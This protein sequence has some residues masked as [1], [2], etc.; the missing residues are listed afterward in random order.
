MTTV[1]LIIFCISVGLVLAIN[2]DDYEQAKVSCLKFVPGSP[3]V[4]RYA[5][6]M[7]TTPPKDLPTVDWWLAIKPA[8]YWGFHYYDS[9]MADANLQNMTFF[10]SVSGTKKALNNFMLNHY[11]VLHGRNIRAAQFTHGGMAKIQNLGKNTEVENVNAL[12]ALGLWFNDQPSDQIKAVPEAGVSQTELKNLLKDD[13]LNKLKYKWK[14]AHSKFA[15][16]LEIK[17]DKTFGDGYIIDHSIPQSPNDHQFM[18]YDWSLEEFLGIGQDIDKPEKELLFNWDFFGNNGLAKA[19]HLFCFN[20]DEAKKILPKISRTLPKLVL[21]TVAKVYLD[22]VLATEDLALIQEFLDLKGAKAGADTCFKKWKELRENN[23]PLTLLTTTAEECTQTFNVQTNLIK[24]IS[25]SPTPHASRLPTDKDGGKDEISLAKL[26]DDT[27]A[28]NDILPGTDKFQTRLLEHRTHKAIKEDRSSW[29]QLKKFNA[30]FAKNL[31]GEKAGDKLLSYWKLVMKKHYSKPVHAT[32]LGPLPWMMTANALKT[33]LYV[34]TWSNIDLPT[35]ILQNTGVYL[36]DGMTM[37]SRR[38]ATDTHAAYET[39]NWRHGQSHEK[40]GVAL[41]RSDDGKYWTCVADGNHRTSEIS[42][43]GVT[44][45]ISSES[46]WKS[47]TAK[48]QH[49]PSAYISEGKIMSGGEPAL[50]LRLAELNN[51]N[52][53]PPV[54]RWHLH[55]SDPSR[56]HLVNGQPTMGLSDRIETLLGKRTRDEGEENKLAETKKHKTNRNNN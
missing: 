48:M 15:L 3:D 20:F 11:R 28:D 5:N 19:Q 46:L 25:H 7:L 56:E 47:L 44:I 51:Q 38:F 30:V 10:P 21:S 2:Y 52:T 42:H 14:H 40:I 55:R 41:R 43:A 12:K 29:S 4:L 37:A 18:S 36:G 31:P 17:E 27:I 9:N 35:I 33:H 53:A 8:K 13:T 6:E 39:D 34:S 22:K 54:F 26:N 49:S 16:G 24:L 1:T 50:D 45:C 23:G 32:F